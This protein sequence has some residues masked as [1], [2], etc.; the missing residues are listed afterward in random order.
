[1]TTIVR[2]MDPKVTQDMDM[3]TTQPKMK[4]KDPYNIAK[5]GKPSFESYPNA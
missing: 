1:M 4:M 2:K 3:E 5:K